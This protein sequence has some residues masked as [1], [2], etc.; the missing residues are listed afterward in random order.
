MGIRDKEGAYCFATSTY[1]AN[2]GQKL[3]QWIQTHLHPS[4]RVEPYNISKA[5]QMNKTQWPRMNGGNV[6][7]DFIYIVRTPTLI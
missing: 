3:L 1:H 5:M 6:H 7:R 2:K 4:V